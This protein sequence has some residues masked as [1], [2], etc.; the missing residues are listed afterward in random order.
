[1]MYEKYKM[2]VMDGHD[3]L[4]DITLDR[5]DLEDF[6]EIMVRNGKTVHVVGGVKEDE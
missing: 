6:I 2:L 3:L 1:M 5:R 4:C